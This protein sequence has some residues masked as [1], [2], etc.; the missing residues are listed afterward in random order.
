[1][2]NRKNRDNGFTLFEL[3]IAIGVVAL[4]AG[5]TI[6]LV[7]SQMNAAARSI[8]VQDGAAASFAIATITTEYTDLG[9]APINDQTAFTYSAA[10]RQLTMTLTGNARPASPLTATARLNLTEGSTIKSSGLSG[11]DWC[12]TIAN[13]G[14]YATYTAAAGLIDGASDCAVDGNAISG[15]DTFGLGQYLADS[16]LPN[17]IS[18]DSEGSFAPYTSNRVTWDEGDQCDNGNSYQVALMEKDGVIG[19]YA[20]TPAFP[21]VTNL[22]LPAD[23]FADQISPTNRVG[24]YGLRLRTVCTLEGGETA[25]TQWTAVQRYSPDPIVAPPLSSV[26][27]YEITWPSSTSCPTNFPAQYRVSLVRIDGSTVG[28]PFQ[29][30][31]WISGNSFTIPTSW[32]PQYGINYGF[33]AVARCQDAGG[34]TTSYISAPS[35]ELTI[36]LPFRPPLSLTGVT[37]DSLGTGDFTADRVRW[38]ASTCPDAGATPSYSAT[39]T[40][41]TPSPVGQSGPLTTTSW[42]MSA[43]LTKGAG[44]G[45]QVSVTCTASGGVES[46]SVT[47]PFPIDWINDPDGVRTLAVTMSTVTNLGVDNDKIDRNTSATC[48]NL[49]VQYSVA[50]TDLANSGATVYT[51]SWPQVDDAVDLTHPT[52]GLLQSGYYQVE[53][54]ARCTDGSIVSPGAPSITPRVFLTRPSTPVASR[55]TTT[56]IRFDWPSSGPDVV[57]EYCWRTASNV[58]AITAGNGTSNNSLTITG[59]PAGATAELKVRANV[60]NTTNYSTISYTSTIGTDTASLRPWNTL[61]ATACNL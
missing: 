20:E 25:T 5:I 13:N 50:V 23:W 31:S 51:T 35:A 39:L 38:N 33:T 28:S 29:T 49:S 45:V 32:M 53:A 15:G 22:S 48:V 47:T 43:L 11:T 44:Y 30:S 58:G 12:I 10:S 16:Y 60:Q 18:L 61:S 21:G 4:L 55:P 27:P 2:L 19:T 17:N 46:E 26:S 9:D 3:L 40:T 14:Q 42:D 52:V 6:P 1:V 34:T 56:S 37:L 57:F 24:T 54:L 41:L 36:G 8:A 7:L 59:L